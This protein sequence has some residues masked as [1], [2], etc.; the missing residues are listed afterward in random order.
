MN[1]R[2]FLKKSLGGLGSAIVAAHPLEI[3]LSNVLSGVFQNSYAQSN[4]I[5]ETFL[6][7]KIISLRLNGGPPRWYWDLPLIPNGTDS[8]LYGSDR[9]TSMLFTKMNRDQSGIQGY[10]GEYATTKVGSSYYLPY[11]WSGKIP[12]SD[13]SSVLMSDLAKNMIMMRGIQT[14]NSHPTSRDM[15]LNPTNTVSLGG[16]VADRSKSPIPA[17]SKESQIGSYK[18]QK[19]IPEISLSTLGS[20]PNPFESVLK[21]FTKTKNLISIKEGTS[22][23]NAIEDALRIMKKTSDAQHPFLPTTYQDRI[24]AKKMLSKTYAGLD[25]AYIDLFNKYKDLISR[26]FGEASLRM[27]GV[28]DLQIAGTKN[29]VFQIKDDMK[30]YFN[31]SDLSAIT[32]KDTTIEHLAESF[33]V[34]EFMITGSSPKSNFEKSFSAS[35]SVFQNN[36]VSNV[37]QLSDGTNTYKTSDPH[38][39]G[40][41]VA[42]VLYS[43]MYRALSACLYEFR[44]QLQS[45][46]IGNGKTLFDESVITIT[47]EFTRNALNSGKGSDHGW[48]GANYTIMSGMVQELIVFGDI[49]TDPN[50][51]KNGEVKNSYCNSWGHGAPMNLWNNKTAIGNAISTVCTMLDVFPWIN[52]NNPSIVQ[53]DKQTGKVKPTY[54]NPENPLIPKNVDFPKS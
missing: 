12:T 16:L 49:Y 23:S 22:T 51:S 45:K 37:I 24:N 32:D 17:V 15:M 34:A 11:L 54:G 36:L 21:P 13:G 29:L 19:G 1:R 27:E 2:N 35:V 30:A 6:E 33:A 20:K 9:K 52:P 5:D 53:K 4:G 43:R 28:D 47:S 7:K 31:G 3:F 44:K 18:S 14:I 39:T 25:E 38:F 50:R 40:S 10:L 48:E 42:L 8:F 41:Y 26:S 46:N